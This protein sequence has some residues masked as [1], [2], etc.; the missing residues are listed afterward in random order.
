MNKWKYKGHRC[1]QMLQIHMLS[2]QKVKKKW[3]QK[4]QNHSLTKISSKINSQL[5]FSF[6]KS[7]Q[8]LLLLRLEELSLDLTRE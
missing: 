1:K 8:Y 5:G 7:V 3:A 2:S 6:Q 4:M